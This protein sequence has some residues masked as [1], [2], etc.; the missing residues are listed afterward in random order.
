MCKAV[1]PVLDSSRY[2]VV[3]VVDQAS[4][5]RAYLGMGAVFS[6]YGLKGTAPVLTHVL[7]PQASKSA[8][9]RSTSMLLCKSIRGLWFL[10]LSWHCH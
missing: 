3:R 2:F 9:T 1:E 10:D 8:L 4:G 7:L 5:Q 6:N